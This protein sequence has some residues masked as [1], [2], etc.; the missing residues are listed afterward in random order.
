LQRSLFFSYDRSGDVVS[1][2][3]GKV[4]FSLAG[5]KDGIKRGK[6]REVSYSKKKGTEPIRSSIAFVTAFGPDIKLVP[7]PESSFV[8]FLTTEGAK[9]N[10]WTMRF[11]EVNE[12]EEWE[13]RAIT[14]GREKPEVWT[15][16]VNSMV[17]AKRQ[18]AWAGVEFTQPELGTR[19]LLHRWPTA[20][21]APWGAG[22]QSYIEIKNRFVKLL[23]KIV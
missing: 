22:G 20:A 23:E 14:A 6:L 5:W 17:E 1:D 2:A 9:D 16:I 19:L 13:F 21:I 3:K 7:I 11:W 12:A 4:P 18:T 15:N 10:F 8:T